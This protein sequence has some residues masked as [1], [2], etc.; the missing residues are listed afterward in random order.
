MIALSLALLL[1]A[2][3]P[4]SPA[5]AAERFKALFTEGEQLFG[6]GDA[7]GAVRAFR[8]AD[9]IRQ[10]PE[11]AWDLA[12]CHEKLR[13]PAMVAYYYRQ[14][15]KRAPAAPDALE[16]AETLATVL[17]LAE[18]EGQG[19]LELESAEAGSVEL[20][21]G[22][23]SGGM[24]QAVF[25]PPGEYAGRVRFANGEQT[26][27]ASMLTGKV[28]TLT[29]SSTPAVAAAAGQPGG[30]GWSP[31]ADLA[32]VQER[33]ASQRVRRIVHDSSLVALGLGVAAL[34]AGGTFGVL[35][36]VDRGALAQAKGQLTVSEGQALAAQSADRAVAAN[37][38]FLVGGGVV[39]AGA[40]TFLFTLPEPAPKGGGR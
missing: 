4:P 20:E 2:A 30:P 40:V 15:L 11:V 7:S 31:S 12:R 14:Y 1:G 9:R 35:S 16:V 39:M 13:E 38:F 26:F 37:T 3:S 17:A 24:P 19:L 6:R 25:L 21:A 33:G 28:T 23:V 29:L 32:R 10:T 8:E 34:A 5:E 18:A 36:Q 27:I 22:R